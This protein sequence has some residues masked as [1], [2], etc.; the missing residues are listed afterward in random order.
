MCTHLWPQ[1]PDAPLRMRCDAY[2]QEIP[3]E[4]ATGSISH[5]EPYPEDHGIRYEK[6]YPRDHEIMY[7]KI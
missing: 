2:T 5:E 3:T 7:E 6:S 1:E 4:L